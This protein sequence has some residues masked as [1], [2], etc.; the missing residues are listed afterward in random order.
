MTETVDVFFSYRSPYSYLAMGRLAAWHREGGVE[1]R[2]RPVLPL[3][4][5]T[6]EFFTKGN[7]L[8]PKY[9]KRDAARVA[10][11]HGIPF[12]WPNPDPV[13]IRFDPVEIPAEQ[14]YIH[15]L[16][17]LGAEA[18]RR[19][20]ALEFTEEVSRVIW[21]GEASWVEGDHLAGAVARAGLSLPELDE[22]ISQETEA[23]DAIIA[24]NQA[25]HA[26]S[27]HWGVPCMVW[28]GEPFFGQDRIDL[29][30]WCVAQAA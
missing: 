11:F 13:V 15:R 26:A 17:R 9:L 23:L 10:A 6:P 25:D 2:I 3:A 28:R 18:Q 12:A 5:R 8:Q 24:Q 20:K 7:P 22:A 21:S 16:T 27:G 4:I 19:G 29:L 1:I 14:P 30:K